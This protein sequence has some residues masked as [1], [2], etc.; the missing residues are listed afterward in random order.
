MVRFKR[1]LGLVLRAARSVVVTVSA[2]RERHAVC[3]R[4]R[5][6]ALRAIGVAHVAFYS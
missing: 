6:F 1:E 5:P 3:K 2:A 4:W